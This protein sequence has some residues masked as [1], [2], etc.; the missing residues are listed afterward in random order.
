MLKAVYGVQRAN[1]MFHVEIHGCMTE[2]DFVALTIDRAIYVCFG[3]DG[4]PRSICFIHVDD[5][6]MMSYYPEDWIRLVA[7]LERRF[8]PLKKVIPSKGHIGVNTKFFPDGSFSTNQKGYILKSLQIV[9]PE[10]KLVPVPTPSLKDLFVNNEESPPV[11]IKW[12]QQ[13]IGILIYTL[14]TRSDIKKEVLFMAKRTTCPTMH[15]LIKVTRI[16]AYLK[17]TSDQGPVFYSSEG[18]TLVAFVDASHNA[19][20]L[21]S[22]SHDGHLIGIGTNG[23]PCLIRSK[24]QSD[25]ICTSATES[26]YV[27]LAYVAKGVVRCRQLLLEMGLPQ[28]SPTIIYSDCKSAVTMANTLDVNKKSQHIQVKYNYTKDLQVKQKLITVTHINREYQRADF[29][30]GRELTASEFIRQRAIFMAGADP[31]ISSN[32]RNNTTVLEEGVVSRI[33]PNMN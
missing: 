5:G 31:E 18:P 7:V 21:S 17:G 32:H 9:D 2:A 28:T 4:K 33:I 23:G 27:A 26:E 3:T 24:V 10:N 6:Q 1:A 12:Y 8:G 19:H 15:D 20:K 14:H 22:R 11:N 29:I 16:F 30:G 25:C 13:L